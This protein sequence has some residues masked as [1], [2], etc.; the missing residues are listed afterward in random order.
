[1]VPKQLAGTSGTQFRQAITQLIVVVRSA[2]QTLDRGTIHDYQE[3]WA[4]HAEVST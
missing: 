3:L 4:R 2:N 1:M